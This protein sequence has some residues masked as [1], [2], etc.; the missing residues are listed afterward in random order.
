MVR[1]LL[2]RSVPFHTALRNRQGR[3]GIKILQATMS[4]YKYVCLSLVWGHCWVCLHTSAHLGQGGRLAVR[5]HHAQGE[6]Q[7]TEEEFR[8][9]SGERWVGQQDD[10]GGLSG[11]APAVSSHIDGGFF[12]VYSTPLVKSLLMSPPGMSLEMDSLCI[13]PPNPHSSTTTLMKRNQLQGIFVGCYILT[14]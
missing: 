1:K 11:E 4:D 3:K 5:A 14:I 12:I 10:D 7:E 13:H 2:A 6:W 8:C 9:E